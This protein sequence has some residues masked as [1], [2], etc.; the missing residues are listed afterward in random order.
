MRQFRITKYDPA[1]RD[2]KGSFLPE[3]WISVSDI[4]RKFAGKEL[5]LAHYKMVES[6]YTETIAHILEEAK[7]PFLHARSVSNHKRSFG[8]PREGNQ[9][10]CESIPGIVGAMLREEFWCRLE[11]NDAFVHVGYDYYMY[12]GVP[13]PIERSIQFAHQRGL[14]VEHFV[15]PYHPEVEG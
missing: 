3:D 6:A 13:H 9:V 10:K 12:V 5:T 1:L 2:E 7:I 14:F 11:T 4:G 8:F 15:S